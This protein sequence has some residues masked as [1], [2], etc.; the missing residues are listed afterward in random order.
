MGH[1]QQREIYIKGYETTYSPK[2][3]TNVKRRTDILFLCRLEL[4]KST[5]N[6]LLTPRTHVLSVKVKEGLLKKLLKNLL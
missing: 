6:G 1:D 3:Y 4:R 5:I 2:I